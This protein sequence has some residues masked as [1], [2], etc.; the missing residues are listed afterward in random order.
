MRTIRL[1]LSIAL[2]LAFVAVADA[3][4]LL[5]VRVSDVTGTPGATVEVP[6]KVAQAA[7]VGAMHIELSY[8]AGVLQ[9]KEV[10]QG[11]L[12]G[13]A[14][15]ES[16]LSVPGQV[17]IGLI[18]ATGLNGDGS[19]AVVVFQ[20]VGQDGDTSPLTLGNL[21][22]HDAATRDALAV[23]GTNGVFQ[24]EVPPSPGPLPP[25]APFPAPRH[26]MT[27]LYLLLAAGGLLVA[28][29][30]F[31]YSQRAPVP[32]RAPVPPPAPASLQL[33]QG[34]AQPQRV[35]LRGTVTTIGRGRQNH[36]TVEDSLVS[37]RHCQIRRQGGEFILEDLGSTNG[38]FL[39]GQRITRKRMRSNDV[40]RVGQTELVFRQ[41]SMGQPRLR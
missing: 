12:A 8:N 28:A 16:N 10:K 24:V 19:V 20:V 37:R 3:Q 18:D 7:N 17:V 38:T 2:L 4:A 32:S 30:A 34:Q 36:V 1:A 22:A 33:R 15:L 21:A 5:T 11:P 29:V 13:G 26:P 6:I 31:Y 40:V 35:E 14:M 39:N 9:A 23:Q 27:W 41:L 25:I